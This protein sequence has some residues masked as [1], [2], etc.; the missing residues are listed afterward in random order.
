VAYLE[1][2]RDLYKYIHDQTLRLANHGY[3][4][5]EIAEQLVLPDSLARNFSNR[6]YY[7]TVCHN[8]KAVYTRYI[9]YFDA[10]P[11]N[12][13]PL[14]PAQAA[15]RYVEYMGGAATVINR[16][17]ESFQA[18][19][20]R[21]VSEVM[22]HVVLAEPAHAEARAL[23]ADT[24]EQLGYQAESGPW[25]NFYLTGALELR[26]GVLSIP[27]GTMNP[28]MLRGIPMEHVFQALGVRLNGPKATGK[29]LS[30]NLTLT[31]LGQA[32]L[33]TVQNAVLNAFENRQDP[34][35]D[36]VLIMASRDFKFMM[37]G[38]AQ[39]ADLIAEEKL[40]LT[41]DIAVLNDF[42]GLFDMFNRL[43]PIVTPRDI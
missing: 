35:P 14:P 1:T 39:T 8:S 12:L 18:G 41:G 38:L 13:H 36:A 11:A 22:N 19:E 31:D 34:S 17:R 25:R 5:D 26:F 7:G 24:Y 42:I 2:Q 3:T 21:W 20:Y 6:D 32:Y 15:R 40:A 28:N 4:R 37:F 43:F 9:G 29:K 23:L 10:N 33:I 16:A 30:F 27:A